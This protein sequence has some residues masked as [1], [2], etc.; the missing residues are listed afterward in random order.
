VPIRAINSPSLKY[1]IAALA[2]KQLGRV[3]G[4]KLSAGGGMFTS[5]ATTEMYPNAA[6]TDWFLKA[7]NYYYMAASDMN[8]SSSFG[9]SAHSSAVLESPIEIVSRWLKVSVL[10]GGTRDPSNGGKFLRKT[11]EILATAVLLI[12]YKLLDA[13]GDQWPTSVS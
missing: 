8:N 6:E 5:S 4:N 3:K 2:A 10:Q 13:D 1:A 9:Y 11:E 7:A 12:F